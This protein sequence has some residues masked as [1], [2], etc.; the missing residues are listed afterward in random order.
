MNKVIKEK[1]NDYISI[2]DMINAPGRNFFKNDLEYTNIIE[3]IKKMLDNYMVT[4]FTIDTIDFIEAKKIKLTA[5]ILSFSRGLY[6]K[7]FVCDLY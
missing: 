6:K 7:E 3:K 1:L 2:C 4:D 5:E